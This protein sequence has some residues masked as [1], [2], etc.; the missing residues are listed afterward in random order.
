MPDDL[1]D[2]GRVFDFA[3]RVVAEYEAMHG[4]YLLQ[5]HATK[6]NVTHV[7]VRVCPTRCTS[8][9][10]LGRISD[11]GVSLDNLMPHSIVPTNIG[12]NDT[13]LGSSRVHPG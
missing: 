5:S 7:P 3:A 12:S 13:A 1:F 8:S 4:S 2:A 6:Y 11:R 10:V 9:R